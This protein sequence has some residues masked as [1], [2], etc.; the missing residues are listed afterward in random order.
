[1]KSDS[2]DD[3]ENN[4]EDNETTSCIGEDRPRE[5]I[6]SAFENRKR[7]GRN[8]GENLSEGKPTGSKDFTDQGDDDNGK[9]VSDT[10]SKTV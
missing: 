10:I 3:K 5:V 2:I 1:M 8:Q 7:L 6:G 9:S 4:T